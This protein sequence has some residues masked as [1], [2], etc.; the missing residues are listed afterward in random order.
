MR[1]DPD[2]DPKIDEP[3]LDLQPFRKKDARLIRARLDPE[4]ETTLRDA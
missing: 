3:E 1:P 2:D 4:K